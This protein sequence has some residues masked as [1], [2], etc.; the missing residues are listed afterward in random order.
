MTYPKRSRKE[1]LLRCKLL[2]EIIRDRSLT[3]KT[4]AYEIL[5]WSISWDSA[6]CPACEYHDTHG[7]NHCMEKCIIHWTGGKGCL[8]LAK[9]DEYSIWEENPTPENADAIVK[10]CDRALGGL[11]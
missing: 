6:L 2:W 10:L 7:G 11:I 4:K 5:G 3:S 9:I 1:S 8:C